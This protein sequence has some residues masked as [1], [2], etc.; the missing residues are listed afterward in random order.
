MQPTSRL[1]LT[2]VLL[3][4]ILISPVAAQTPVEHN[5][6][7]DGSILDTSQLLPQSGVGLTVDFSEGFNDITTL[8]TQGWAFINKSD[9]IGVID[10]F[11]GNSDVFPAHSGD[12]TQYIAANFNNAA[13][14]GTIS[15]WLILPTRLFK[16]GDTLSFYT[17]TTLGSVWADRLEVRMSFAGDSEDV[18][19]GALDVGDFD[20]FLASINP[21]LISDGYPTEWT[22]ITV[23]INLTQ[24]VVG[25]IALRYFVTNAGPNGTNSNYIGIDSLSYNEGPWVT[26]LPVVIK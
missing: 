11:Q 12:A 20:H 10:W 23:P 22:E 2:F 8:P 13:G 5:S 16:N 1:F 7:R 25:R 4:S 17:R 21:D 15:N 26:Y 6:A 9:P 19:V 14:V 24:P 3:M 18:G